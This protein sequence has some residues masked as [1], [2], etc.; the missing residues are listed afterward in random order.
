[1]TKDTQ[2]P[3]LV[4]QGSIEAYIRAANQYPMLTA[5]EEKS[6][7]SVCIMT[8]TLRPR[9]TDHVASAVCYP[10][11]PQLFRLWPASG[12]SYPGRQY[13]ADESGAPF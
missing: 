9:K 6:W 8:A 7:L 4:P 3:V 10:C 12:G 1:M 11:R 2:F 5:E 13:R